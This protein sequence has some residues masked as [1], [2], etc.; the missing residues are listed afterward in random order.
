MIRL[1]WTA[2]APAAPLGGLFFLREPNWLL[3]TTMNPFRYQSQ[4]DRFLGYPPTGSIGT[5][6][7][8]TVKTG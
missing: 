3:V 8:L 6:S 4:F 2:P 5:T 7:T 1:S